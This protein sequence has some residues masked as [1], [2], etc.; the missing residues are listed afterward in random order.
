[1]A[2]IL[3]ALDLGGGYG[4]VARVL[5][6]ADLLAAAGHEIVLALRPAGDMGAVLGARRH[7]V[8][9]AP[10]LAGGNGGARVAECYADVLLRTG[11]DRPGVLERLLRDWMALFARERPALVISEF[12]PTAMLA[13]RLAGQ[14]QAVMGCGYTL[15]PRSRPMPAM[16]RWVSVPASRIAVSEARALAIINAALVALGGAPLAALEESLAADA[17]FLCT[18]PEFD[19]YGVRAGAAYYGNAFE[20]RAGVAPPWPGAGDG[21][22]GFAYLRAGAANVLPMMRAMA[23]EGIETVLHARELSAAVRAALPAGIGLSAVPVRV[24]EAVAACAVVVCHSPGTAAAAL[25]A[26]RPVLLLPEH[27]EQEMVAERLVSQ[28]LALALPPSA[29]EAQCRAA[30]RALLDQPR[31]AAA[32][33]RF[34]AHYHGYDPQDAAAAVAEECEI[35]LR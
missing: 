33:R 3:F 30:L 25:M 16:R 4:H 20:V 14:R 23:A 6:V 12:A 29:D 19:H 24:G 15:P 7:R 17:A 18:F 22:R 10:A 31:F 11:Y 27:V 8:V 13:A 32:A 28:G 21:A 5:P 9:A 1:M 35:L 26:G 2:K 34:A